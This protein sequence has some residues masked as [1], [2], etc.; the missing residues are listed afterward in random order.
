MV[1]ATVPADG[2]VVD[3]SALVLPL[4]AAKRLIA[5]L[6]ADVTQEVRGLSFM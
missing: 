1:S 2:L 4:L 3:H 5:H 6:P